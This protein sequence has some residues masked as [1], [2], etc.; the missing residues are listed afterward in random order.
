VTTAELV[1]PDPCRACSLSHTACAWYRERHDQPCCDRCEHP[2]ARP[3]GGVAIPT[4]KEPGE[5]ARLVVP[6]P[7]RLATPRIACAIAQGNFTF[8]H[9]RDM[10]GAVGKDP[11][12]ATA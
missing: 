4:L 2:D 1:P 6:L 9:R 12:P 11:S 8:P 3:Q 7:P 10:I 5:T